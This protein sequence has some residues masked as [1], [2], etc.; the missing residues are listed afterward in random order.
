MYHAYFPQPATVPDCSI[1]LFAGNIEQWRLRGDKV[2]GAAIDQ[3][4]NDLSKAPYFILGEGCM[5][6]SPE[7]NL[8]FARLFDLIICSMLQM[9]LMVPDTAEG[10]GLDDIFKHKLS[11]LNEGESNK[12]LICTEIIVFIITEW[13]IYTA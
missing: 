8:L 3:P 6:P 11:R 7:F 13:L 10:H 2:R 12:Y 9:G 5:D 4:G 1:H